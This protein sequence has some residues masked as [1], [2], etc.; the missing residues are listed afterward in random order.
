MATEAY[1]IYS[2]YDPKDREELERETGAEKRGLEEQ[3]AREAEKTIAL[4]E[5]GANGAFLTI[6]RLRSILVRRAGQDANDCQFWAEKELSARNPSQT[7][8][9]CRK[10]E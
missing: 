2:H 9:S 6:V 4:A 5:K 7:V 10:I 1:T 3:S 8:P